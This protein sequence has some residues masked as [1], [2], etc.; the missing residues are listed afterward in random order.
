VNQFPDLSQFADPEPLEWRG[1][2]VPLRKD[3]DKTPKGFAVTLSPVLPQRDLRPFTRVTVHWGKGNNQTGQ[4]SALLSSGSQKASC[5]FDF[6]FNVWG[7]EAGKKIQQLKALD[8][9]LEY[10]CLTAHSSSRLSVT[11]VSRDPMQSSV[12]HGCCTHVVHTCGTHVTCAHK[13]SHT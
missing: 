4:Q 7:L 11:L 2:Q 10:L 12:F 8:V 9:P 5:S 6:G 13:Y 3:L 1:G